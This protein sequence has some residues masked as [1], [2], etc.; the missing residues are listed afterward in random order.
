[1]LDAMSV[2]SM[3]ARRRWAA[4]GVL[5]GG[6]LVVMM[7][8]TILIMALPDLLADLG[9]T[10]TQQLWIVDAYSLALAGLI[11]PMSALA[12]R[13]GRRLVL[14]AGFATFGLVS[15]LVVSAEASWQVIALRAALGA[16]G[17]AIMPTTL[18]MLRVVFRDPVERTRALALWSMVAGAGAVLGP[19]VGG[20]LLQFFS[21]HAAF[22]VNVPVVLLAV[23]AG[24]ALLPESRDPD[25][26]RWDPVGTA[27]IIA[28]MVLTVWGVKRVAEYGIDHLGSW[29]LL[30]VG[31]ALTG[32]FVLR[33]LR[34]EEPMLEVRLFLSGPFT[35]GVLAALTTSLAMGGVL[36]LVAQW[37]QAVAGY[38]PVV[39]G[40]ALLPMALGGMV[41]AAVAPPLAQRVGAG[42]VLSGGLILAAAGM[43][44]LALQPGITE[45]WH[46]AWPIAL[47]GAGMGP[48]AIASA[49]IMGATPA[50]KAGNAAAI[51][52]ATYDIG[53]VLGV[54]VL[55]SVA[56]AV[57]RDHLRIGEAIAAGALPPEAALAEESIVAALALASRAG[58]PTL[59]QVAERAFA[60]GIG[61]AAMVGGVLLAGAALLAVVLIPRDHDLAAVAH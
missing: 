22:L 24:M 19:L 27:V 13:Y 31:L 4:A 39:A 18:S 41:T 36:L 50:D 30:A 52:E 53:N 43:F 46:V 2:E 45:Y 14:L 58:A 17:A 40:V 56:G 61:V 60:D 51:E 23:L 54:A 35:A 15:A 16:A 44:G 8:M 49:I 5:S 7:D 1:M 32:A 55:G 21:W 29:G 48:L 12:D 10:A 34:R 59:A 38:D 47:V 57:Y 6:L 9:S 25:P 11:I 26:P 37:L 33:C 42:P 20:T 3:S 28:G